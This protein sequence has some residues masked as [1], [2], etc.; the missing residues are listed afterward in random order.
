MLV[1]AMFSAGALTLVA[2]EETQQEIPPVD[3]QTSVSSN[4]SPIHPTFTMLDTDGN[5]VLETGQPVSTMQTCGQCHDTNFI[6]SHSFHADVG[7]ASM[8]TLDET[9]TTYEWSQSLGYFG[10]WNPI[11]YRY[12]SPLG[13]DNVDLTTAEWIQIFGARH[14]GGGPA[15]TSR[16]G[17]PL[18]EQTDVVQTVENA[19]VDPQTGQLIPWNWDVSGIVEM[20]CFLCHIPDP[21]HEARTS[22][23][24]SGNFAWA[25]TATLVSTGI[26]TADEATQEWLWNTDAF[27]PEGELQA[28]FVNIQDPRSDACGACHGAVHLDAQVPLVIEPCSPQD[29]RTYTTGQVISPQKISESGL[30]IEDK[31]DANYAWDIH[32]ERVLNCVDCHYSL[33]NPIYFTENAASRPE[34]LMFDPRRMDFGEYLWRP[35]HQFA[36]GSSAQS[37]LAPQLDNT[38]R[39]CESCHNYEV[40]HTWLPYQERHAATLACESCHIPHLQAPALQSVDWTVLREDGQAV[41]LCRGQTTIEGTDGDG[42]QLITGYEP[43]LLPRPD[44]DGNFTLAPHNLVSAWYWVYGEDTRPVPLRDLQSVW[45]ESDR[46]YA[47]DIVE[48]FD[49]NGDEQLSDD[50]LHITTDEQVNFITAKLESLGLDSPR[51]VA[52]VQPYSINHNVIHGDWATRD[53]QACHAADSRLT[54]ALPLANR[55]PGGVIPE[56][57]NTNIAWNGELQSDDDGQLFFQPTTES[58]AQTLYVF[59]HSSN[60]L[61]DILGTLMFIGVWLGVI[62]HGGLRYLAARRRSSASSHH[63]AELEEAYMYGVY[64]RFWHW[65]QTLVIFL[66]IFT[67]LIIHRPEQF[68]LFSFAFVVEVH[69]ILAIILVVNAALAAFYHIVSGE[70]RQFLPQPRGFFNQM[71][72]QAKY[73]IGGIFRNDPHPF[74]RTPERKLNPLQQVTY[75][76]I[77]NVLLPAQIIT[78]ALMWGVQ[79]WQELANLFGGLPVL[80]PIHT[81]IAWMFASFIVLHVYLTTTGHTPLAGIKSMM[82]GWDEIETHDS[83]DATTNTETTLPEGGTAS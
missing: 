63:E 11:T 24:A 69:N 51:I 22:A 31:N 81:L 42:N 1:I 16:D 25:N 47:S 2:Q 54:T 50:E 9:T 7:L 45:F 29:W 40:S 55:L 38:L 44:S 19:I 4:A 80:A 72:S 26:V 71:F 17:E 20:N 77:L 48:I 75:L 28:E 67:G 82:L 64:E 30:N 21:D 35:L 73:Y 13:D 53:C 43:V 70:I 6:T 33:N 83:T 68:S 49:A 46:N 12:L 10:A 56:L 58:E 74:E 15:A 39:R 36:K 27:T 76:M 65:L 34:H 41:T 3:E 61:V 79:E 52:D 78:G 18:N 8:A 59:G 62:G 14:V 32:A 5:P 66:L 37:S 57:N 23:L 60:A